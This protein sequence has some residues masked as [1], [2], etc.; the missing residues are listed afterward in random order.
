MEKKTLE[1]K[2]T[3]I[4]GTYSVGKKQANKKFTYPYDEKTL[5]VYL[6]KKLFP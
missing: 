1:E 3:A 5:Y 2:T 6:Q 4:I